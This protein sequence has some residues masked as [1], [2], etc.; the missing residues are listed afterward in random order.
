MSAVD[1]ITDKSAGAEE[2]FAFDR[3]ISRLCEMQSEE[4]WKHREP[5]YDTSAI[6]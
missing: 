4:Y 2:K 6:K 5:T 3:T 1:I